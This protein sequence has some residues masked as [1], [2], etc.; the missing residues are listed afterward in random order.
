[1][2]TVCCHNWQ[3]SLV[4]RALHFDSCQ[5]FDWC[6]CRFPASISVSSRKNAHGKQVNTWLFGPHSCG[7][8]SNY[9]RNHDILR[10]HP[11]LTSHDL[12]GT[13]RVSPLV[14]DPPCRRLWWLHCKRP[15][16]FLRRSLALARSRVMVFETQGWIWMFF[17]LIN[18]PCLDWWFFWIFLAYWILEGIYISFHF[19]FILIYIH[20]LN[21]YIYIYVL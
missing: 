18:H 7:D 19:H 4:S 16:Q 20:H 11:A 3:K 10:N 5:L 13:T 8:G 14:F 12:L 15:C 17:T 9:L 21:K 6:T 2:G 1:M